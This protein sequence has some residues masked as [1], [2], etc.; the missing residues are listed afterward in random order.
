MRDDQIHSAP[1]S[2]FQ[3][4]DSRWGTKDA[5]GNIHDEAIY[6]RI[7]LE[8]GAVRYYDGYSTVCEFS[9]ING[10]ELLTWSE[11]WWESAFMVTHYPEEYNHY[12][13]RHIK[14][15]TELDENT[16]FLPQINS[17]ADLSESQRKVIEELEFYCRE[18]DNL[19]IEDEEEWYETKCSKLSPKERVDALLPLM[20][21]PAIPKDLKSLLWYAVFRFNDWYSCF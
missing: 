13:W 16:Q 17:F 10:M 15:N 5:N 7:E 3:S 8:N 18:E 1:Y 14:L 2:L 19:E 11:P 4:A 9:P 21:E 20:Q 6:E 12:I